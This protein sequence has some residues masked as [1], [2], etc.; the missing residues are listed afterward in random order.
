V[1]QQELSDLTAA[2]ACYDKTLELDPNQPGAMWNLAL[3]LEQQNERHW[4]EKLYARIPENSPEFS[5]ACFRLGYLRLLR[6]DYAASGDAFQQCLLRRPE[7]PEATLNAAIA[8]ARSGRGKEARRYFEETLMMR[9]DSSDAVRGLAALALDQQDYDAAYELH[10][11]LIQMGERSPELL[12]NAGLICH[13][14]GEME[15]AIHFYEQAL[16]EDPQFAEALLNLG[17]AQMALG[18]EDDARSSWRK[19]IR[20]KPELAQTYFEP[21]AN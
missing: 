13:K 15:E 5:D 20:E 4:A 9:P 10:R 1:A 11:R 3:V 14:R 8:L 21:S 7:W 6:G 12:Y 17:H 18:H 2:R 19:A 16:A